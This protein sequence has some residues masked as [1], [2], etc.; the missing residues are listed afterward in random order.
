MKRAGRATGRAWIELDMNNLR[1]NV[2]LVR[3][4]LPGACQIMASVKANAYGHGAVGFCRELNNLGVRAFCVA[5]VLEG[6]ELRKGHIEGEILVLGYTHP[7][8]F[9]LLEK[10]G[11]TQTV[12]DLEYAELLNGFGEKLAVHV[13]ID[14]GLR[15]LGERS[16]N[17]DRIIRIFKCRNLVI[18]GIYTHLRAENDGETE[19]IFT[20]GQIECF[21]DVCAE[22][23]RRGLD[24]PKSHIQNS[25]GFLNHPDLV[26]DY[27][28]IG[29]VL[30]GTLNE[31]RDAE[32]YGVKLRPV[33][34][35]KTRIG[36]VKTVSA[37]EYIGYGFTFAASKE[38]KIAVLAIGYADGLPRSLSH[39]AG[40]ALING[41]KAP[42]LGDVCMDQTMVDVTN[43]ENAERGD[44]A[45][46]IG[47]SGEAE[48]TAYDVAVQAGTISSEVLSR[49]GGRLERIFAI[50]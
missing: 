45:V 40:H 46:I 20:K 14:T 32:K 23:G 6:L 43:I 10:Y 39:G 42:V 7:D 27:V 16:E 9:R 49:L 50:L 29:R 12:L 15:R 17:M 30:Y 47:K 28:R 25:Y 24:L 3:E 37:G 26:Y 8:R 21:Q 22:I 34:S 31:P 19:N 38:M 48:T 2:N 36:A 35:L 44:I 1:Y 13:K 18:T 33:L 5:S 11:L 4:R 41:Q